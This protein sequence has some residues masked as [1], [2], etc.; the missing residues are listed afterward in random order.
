MTYY[1]N[2]PKLPFTFILVFCTL[3]L[4]S[5]AWAASY[6]VTDLGTLGGSRS[7][8]SG[9]ND[10]GQIVGH[11]ELAGNAV[12]RPFLY[13]NGS[14]T[15]LGTLGGSIGYAYAI[16]NSGQV[17]GTSYTA[18]NIATKA[19]LYSSGNM[20]GLGTLGGANSYAYDINNSGQ[21]VGASQITSP[22]VHHAFLFSNSVMSDLGS[23]SIASSAHGINDSGQVV[24]TAD[25]T[26]FLYSQGSMT[27]LGPFGVDFLGFPYGGS[28][29]AINATGQIVGNLTKSPLPGQSPN[30]Q[31][32][33][34]TNGTY[35]L[36]GGGWVSDINDSGQAVGSLSD[37]VYNGVG[38][39]KESFGLLYKNG[40]AIR[41]NSLIDPQ[42]GWAIRD[43]A[44]INKQ[45]QIAAWGCR[46]DGC[47]AVLLNPVP[48]PAA[49]LLFTSGLLG[50]GVFARRNT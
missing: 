31:A 32:I 9:I 33:Q 47:R 18:G 16:N 40:T 23:G 3:T 22:T 27:N 10:S 28:A 19:F 24:G 38:Y 34:F 44:G 1:E 5:P 46:S 36:L 30:S 26:A 43:A 45:G 11:S 15:D 35:T 2:A 25:N 12:V 6:T 14:M 50:L 20:T 13:S 49:V 41:L 21:I 39:V 48:L 17:V 8:A 37:N 7:F 42:S 4:S 29:T